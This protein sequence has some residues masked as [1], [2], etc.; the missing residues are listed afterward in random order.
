MST[1]NG[2]CSVAVLTIQI[3][4]GLYHTHFHIY[5]A[6]VCLSFDNEQESWKYRWM[7]LSPWGV[8][9]EPRVPPSTLELTQTSRK[10]ERKVS[11]GVNI[12]ITIIILEVK[13]LLPWKWKGTK[14]S[15]STSGNNF[16]S[17]YQNALA[18]SPTVLAAPSVCVCVCVCMGNMPK[19]DTIPPKKTSSSI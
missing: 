13:H 6:E 7:G 19:Y 18:Q 10:R 15:F 8:G 14:H 12:S 5:N 3:T 16:A 1:V 9:R 11:S 17:F 2:C 4:T